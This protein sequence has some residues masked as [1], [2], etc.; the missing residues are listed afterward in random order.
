MIAYKLTPEQAEVLTGTEFMPDN[1]FA[2]IEDINGDKFIS[3]EEVDQCV[4]E[5]FQWVK[6]LQ[7]AEFIKPIPT[8]P[9]PIT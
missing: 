6:E 4:N 3:V 7:P 5:Q 2:P 1:Y 9:F 8:H